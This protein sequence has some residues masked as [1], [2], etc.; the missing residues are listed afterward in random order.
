MIVWLNTKQLVAQ[1]IPLISCMLL[2]SPSEINDIQ[3]L[4]FNAYFP[5]EQRCP[6]PSIITLFQLATLLRS[7]RPLVYEKKQQ[8]FT[9]LLEKG[10][11]LEDWIS[12][13]AVTDDNSHDM[14]PFHLPK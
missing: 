9:G 6:F 14:A 4:T 2:R 5:Q 7:L 12:K 1:H 13:T 3:Y 10:S 11:L 8:F